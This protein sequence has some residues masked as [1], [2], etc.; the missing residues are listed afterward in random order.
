[1]MPSLLFFN[2][3]YLLSF[4]SAYEDKQHSK[5]KEIASRS[6]F[7]FTSS[8]AGGAASSLLHKLS[9]QGKEAAVAK[10][11][12]SSHSPLIRR[13]TGES[14]SKNE[15]CATVTRRNSQSE[16]VEERLKVT[17]KEEAPCARSAHEGEEEEK[18]GSGLN[19]STTTEEVHKKLTNAADCVKESE[20][21]TSS[22]GGVSLVADYSDSDSD[23][24]QSH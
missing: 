22:G 7:N 16:G 6:W 1:M 12:G 20:K 5:R 13:R 21:G 19:N 14:G 15:P 24:T 9:L 11:L 3:I 10:A 18:H 17:Q 2:F 8:P 4:H 23:S